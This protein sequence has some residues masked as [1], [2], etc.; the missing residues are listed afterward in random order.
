MK[1]KALCLMLLLC[2]MLGGCNY[3]DG[4]YVSVVPHEKSDYVHGDQIE[5]PSNYSQLRVVLQD[6]I[7]SGI[8]ESVIDVSLF[9][10]AQ[11]EKSIDMAIRYVKTSYPLA[12]YA[13]NDI[14]YDLGTRAGASAIAVKIDYRH[15]DVAIRQILDVSGMTQAKE[16]IAKALDNCS[17]GVVLMI[18]GYQDMDVTQFVSDYAQEHPESVMEIPEVAA[19]VYPDTGADRVLELRFTYQNSRE[20]LRKMQDEVAP[21]F[22]SAKLYV[23]GAGDT[24]RKYN[25]LYALLTERFSYEY[26][27]VTSITP[28]YS[29]LIHGVGDEKAFAVVYSYMCRQAGMECMVVTGTYNGEP[30]TWNIVR[31]NG[32]FSHVDLLRCYRQGY[33]EL[34]SDQDMVGYVWDYSAYPACVIP[35]Q[36]T[37]EPTE[38]S[39]TEAPTDPT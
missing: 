1:T 33:F 26:D 38:P 17:A 21:V 2:L 8:T 27:I 24:Q 30:H 19:A 15:S 34:N 36:P 39:Q 16:V 14:T 28:S 29:L 32:I 23:S 22:A 20:K 31:N 3:T 9:D 13:V 7:R 11:L 25:M 12:A 37:T 35:I 6:L 18:R 10:P 4:R 5:Q